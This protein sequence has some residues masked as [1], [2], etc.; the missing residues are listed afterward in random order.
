[1]STDTKFET[2]WTTLNQCPYELP[3]EIKPYL[4]KAIQSAGFSENSTI[5]ASGA[6]ATAATGKVKKLSG[7]N[8]YM[9]EK[10]AELKEQNVPSGERMTKVSAMWKVL[11]DEEKGTWK[12]KAEGLTPSTTVPA[13]TTATATQTLVTQPAAISAPAGPKKLSGYQ[14]YVKETMAVV[15]ANPAIAAKERMGE[16]GKMWKAL[17]DEQKTAYKVKAETL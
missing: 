14:L 7:Y 4:Q 1:M 8:L 17:S 9:R 3:V 6:V 11:T 16:I 5:S 13:T 15:K 12:V 10:M 2:F